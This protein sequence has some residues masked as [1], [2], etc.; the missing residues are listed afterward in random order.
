LASSDL[1]NSK[2]VAQCLALYDDDSDNDDD[3]DKHNGGS[4]YDK[5][6]VNINNHLL[7]FL[8]LKDCGIAFWE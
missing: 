4:Q 8:S 6:V 7:M 1:I 5:H 3:N 2:S